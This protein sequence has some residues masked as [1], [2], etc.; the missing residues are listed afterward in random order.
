[1]KRYLKTVTRII[2]V[3]ILLP[4]VSFAQ[5]HRAYADELFK[6]ADYYKAFFLYRNLYGTNLEENQFAQ[7]C[8][9]AM[10]LTKQFLDLRAS[11]QYF[12]AKTK[13]RELLIINPDDFHAPILPQLSI[14]EATY[15]QRIALKQNSVMEVNLMLDK[16]I[17]LY[18]QGQTDGLNY[19]EID[20]AIKQCEA[21]KMVNGL[22]ESAPKLSVA[23][24]LINPPI[25]V[26]TIPAATVDSTAQITKD[27]VI[28]SSKKLETT[29]KALPTEVKVVKTRTQNMLPRG[30]VANNKK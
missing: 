12:D 8:N 3:V 26:E 22:T 20:D 15:W 5:T 17:A 28:I 27:D 10:V 29:E 23:I 7:R 13:L 6:K 9:Q 1:M 19:K 25:V 4:F 24:P 16:A 2:I 18:Q 21:S 14:E 11:K 30:E